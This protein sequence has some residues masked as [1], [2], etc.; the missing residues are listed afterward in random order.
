MK[1]TIALDFEKFIP[2]TLNLAKRSNHLVAA[3][4]ERTFTKE[5]PRLIEKDFENS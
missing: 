2:E 5:S 3:Q 4:I 1:K